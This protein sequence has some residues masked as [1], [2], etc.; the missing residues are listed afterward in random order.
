MNDQGRYQPFTYY[1]LMETSL[2]ELLVEKGI[3]PNTTVKRTFQ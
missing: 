3:V 1:Q 2:R